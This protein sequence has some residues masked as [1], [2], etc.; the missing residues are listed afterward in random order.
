MDKNQN[1]WTNKN[2]KNQKIKETYYNRLLKYLVV[3]MRRNN[4][5]TKKLYLKWCNLYIIRYYK[6]KYLVSNVNKTLHFETKSNPK[7]T[8]R[9][10]YNLQREIHTNPDVKVI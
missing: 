6:L 9:L 8:I 7:H 4:N 3:C 2:I 10:R 5:Q 1:N